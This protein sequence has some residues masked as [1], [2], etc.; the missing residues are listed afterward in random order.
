MYAFTHFGDGILRVWNDWSILLPLQPLNLTSFLLREGSGITKVLHS[1]NWFNIA[2]E[3]GYLSMI[4][5][6]L[7]IK[8]GDF[9]M[10]NSYVFFKW[11]PPTLPAAVN[12]CLSGAPNA[13][14]GS[15]LDVASVTAQGLGP[16][17]RWDWGWNVWLACGMSNVFVCVY[18][19]IYM[20]IQMCNVFW[21]AYIYISFQP[22]YPYCKTS[23]FLAFGHVLLSPS[24]VRHHVYR[25][26]MGEKV[27]MDGGWEDGCFRAGYQNC[28]FFDDVPESHASH[29]CDEW[30]GTDVNNYEFVYTLV[31]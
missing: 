2:T 24:R 11:H 25:S 17:W 26:I 23:A 7:P 28:S 30:S 12:L 19:N 6:D 27:R 8:P 9:P 29:A 14:L 13:S 16:G 3:K 20:H 5:H 18:H 4:Y 22:S 21:Y 15:A 31:I 10:T 1:G